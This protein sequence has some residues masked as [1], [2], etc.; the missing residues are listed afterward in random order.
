MV[1]EQDKR[2][3]FLAKRVAGCTRCPLSRTRTRSVVGE[4][5]LN[6]CIMFVGEAPGYYEDLQGRP[7]VGAAGKILDRVLEEI[8]VK[9]SSVYI[10]NIVKSR[11]PDNRAPRREEIEAC[12]TYLDEQLDTIRPKVIVSLG[13]FSTKHLMEKLGLKPAPISSIRGRSHDALASYGPVLVFPL[14][15]PAVALYKNE[16]EKELFE[17]ARCLRKVLSGGATSDFSAP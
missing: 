8:G 6:T 15:H 14:Y 9:R 5:E 4:G 12:S 2:M 7:F 11:P 13:R 1:G 17:D 10:T 16:M 3:E